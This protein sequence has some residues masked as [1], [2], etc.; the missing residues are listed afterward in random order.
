MT[1]RLKFFCPLGAAEPELLVLAHPGLQS[2][3]LGSSHW[4]FFPALIPFPHMLQS[5]TYSFY[6]FLTP[7]I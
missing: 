7:S 4:V 2:R 6:S 1:L 5:F 3:L